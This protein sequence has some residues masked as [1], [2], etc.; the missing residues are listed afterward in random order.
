MTFRR[1][2]PD[3]PELFLGVLAGVVVAIAGSQAT[4]L[5]SSSVAMVVAAVDPASEEAGLA[6]FGILD[7][8]LSSTFR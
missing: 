4:L 7:M 6:R 5:P 8:N 2:P 3:P 1:A